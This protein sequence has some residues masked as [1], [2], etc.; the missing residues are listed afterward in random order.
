MS[1][2]KIYDD[3]IAG[4]VPDE[5]DT[6]ESNN[7]KAWNIRCN[8]LTCST[9]N[10]GN[11]TSVIQTSF[12]LAEPQNFNLFAN[13]SVTFLPVP[14]INDIGISYN[15]ISHEFTLP[16]SITLLIDFCVELVPSASD[17]LFDI[18]FNAVI[19]S[20][21]VC[22]S[23]SSCGF[24]SAIITTTPGANILRINTNRVGADATAKNNFSDKSTYIRFIRIA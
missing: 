19:F 11:I 10:N 24:G 4:I 3:N 23:S 7:I 8:N 14:I 1:Y 12:Y 20:D 13:S 15:N 16:A 6:P 17:V 18:N 5:L 22:Y 9:I 21:F 2:N